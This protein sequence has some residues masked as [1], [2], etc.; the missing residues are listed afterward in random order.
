MKHPI[1]ISALFFSFL[2]VSCAT[3]G[4]VRSADT[5]AQQTNVGSE[6]TQEASCLANECNYRVSLEHPGFY[7]AVVTLPDDQKEGLWG[8]ILDAA[9]PYVGGFHGGALLKEYS[10]VPSWLAFSLSQ[11]EALEVT[12]SSYLNKGSPFFIQADK[13]RYNPRLESGLFDYSRI[14]VWEV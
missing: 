7:I 3:L 12:V 9:V 4:E 2:S 13:Q 10:L 8:L 11:P 6:H 5:T 14:K 1:L